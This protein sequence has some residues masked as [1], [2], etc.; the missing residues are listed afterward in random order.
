MAERIEVRVASNGRDFG[1][2]VSYAKGI[3]GRYNPESKTWSIPAQWEANARTRGLIKVGVT[4][5][6]NPRCT[7]PSGAMGGVC[8]CC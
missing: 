5:V 1:K 2:S 4:S 8:T 3:G 6:R 7:C